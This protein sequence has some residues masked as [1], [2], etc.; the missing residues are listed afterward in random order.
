MP[1]IEPGREDLRDLQGLHLW[2]GGMSNCSQ[3]CRIT[4]A[5]LGLEFESHLMNLQAGEHATEEFQQINP[6]GVVPVLI[7][8]G[9]VI[10]NSVDI[11]DYLDNTLGDSSLRPAHLDAAI[12]ESL[13]H[14]DKSQLAL[15]YCTFEFFFQH[16]PRASEETYQKLVNG[17][18]SK[19][20]Q[21]FWQE[22]RNGFAR[23]RIHDMVARAHQ[24]F[25]QLEIVLNDGR[26]WM[27]GD[28]F[29]LADI[30]WMPN[31]HRFD[32]LRW[33]LNIYPN[34]KR[35]FATAS[36]RPSY[37]TALDGWEPKKLME[38]A[39][40]TLDKRR[41]NNDGIDSYGPFSSA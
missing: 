25:L 2:H 23:E 12:A 1:I 13:D 11:I 38:L 32:L 40:G 39:L 19:F 33:P 14:A 35:W 3:R 10:V 26:K 7:H 4:L 15:K 21:E 29:S 8:D 36:T 20:L 24:D 28:Q 37:S 41:E 18:Q 22:Y 5:E 16:G 34:L 17:L 27:A 30:A 31:F 9:T 6:N